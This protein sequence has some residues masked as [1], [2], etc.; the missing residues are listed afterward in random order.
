MHDELLTCAVVWTGVAINGV[1]NF[2]IPLLLY[3]CAENNAGALLFL[4]IIDSQVALAVRNMESDA[5]VN[6]ED[7]PLPDFDALPRVSW[8][9]PIPTT[10]VRVEFGYIDSPLTPTLDSP[11]LYQRAAH[12]Y[13]LA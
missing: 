6:N 12:P 4:Q 8:L 13:L 11:R 7:D 3:I 1:I 9:P 5:I 2:V 10:K